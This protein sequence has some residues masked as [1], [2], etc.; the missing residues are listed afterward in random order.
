MSK[1]CNKQEEK[2]SFLTENM[3]HSLNR[4]IL[5]DLVLR[6]LKRE[7][8]N[9]KE[10][11]LSKLMIVSK[12]ITTDIISSFQ[13]IY[14]KDNKKRCLAS[15]KTS[16]CIQLK[17]WP[18]FSRKA[19][20]RVQ[21]SISKKTRK[22]KSIST[23]MKVSFSKNTSILPAKSKRKT[24]TWLLFGKTNF[25]EFPIY[26]G[27]EVNIR[28]NFQKAQVAL[29]QK[30]YKLL[31]Q[32][33]K[34]EK[35][36][37]LLHL[38]YSKTNKSNINTKLNLNLTRFIKATE[39]RNKKLQIQKELEN[40]GT[41]EREEIVNRNLRVQKSEE[42]IQELKM[43]KKYYQMKLKLFYIDLLE[44]FEKPKVHGLTA[45]EILRK[46]WNIKGH[47]FCSCNF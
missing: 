6:K 23:F 32:L 34:A 40:Y 43:R 38:P 11:P 13:V 15:L 27:F 18:E 47:F 26:L 5:M 4:E 36:S 8:Y 3:R 12:V 30:K 19:I 39:F 31:S 16:E 29:K 14:I 21:P 45:P 24:K 22:S 20:S 2:I 28:Q 35:S 44:C 17:I 9:K 41:E 25:E 33:N 42:E 37:R 1:V 46:L 7:F 10:A